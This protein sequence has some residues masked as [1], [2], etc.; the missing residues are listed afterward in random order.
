MWKASVEIPVRVENIYIYICVVSWC[1]SC[2]G[3]S[4]NRRDGGETLLIAARGGGTKAER[5]PNSR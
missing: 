3:V 4:K 1:V 5:K 2:E